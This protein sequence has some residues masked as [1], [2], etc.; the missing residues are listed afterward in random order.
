[1]GEHMA[2]KR[3]IWTGSVCA[4]LLGCATFAPPSARVNCNSGQCNVDVHVEN[5]VI[6][7]P[8]VHV[9]QATNIFWNIDQASKQAGYKYPNDSAR[10]GIWVKQGPLPPP[11]RQND[12][13]YK[14]HDNNQ[15]KGAFPYG[16]RVVKGSAA[17]S[18]LDPSIV[19]H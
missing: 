9:F 19:N 10:P 15:D 5:C 1:M 17:C 14:L 16:V 4:L 7:A 2:T 12:W 11:E 18:D 6:T 8:D 13:T 3:S